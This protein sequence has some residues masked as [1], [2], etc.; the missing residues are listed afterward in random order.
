ML[1]VIGLFAAASLAFWSGRKESQLFSDPHFIRRNAG[2]DSLFAREKPVQEE[3]PHLFEGVRVV[4]NADSLEVRYPALGN[5]PENPV[6]NELVRA[7]AVQTASLGGNRLSLQV[8]GIAYPD[9]PVKTNFDYAVEME[10]AWFSSGLKPIP[11]KEVTKIVA[12]GWMRRLQFRGAFPEVKFLFKCDHPEEI[13]FMEQSVFNS[14]THQ[15]LTTGSSSW[16]SREQ[17]S[18]E[19]SIGLWYSAPVEVVLTV[20]Q[21]PVQTNKL[22]LREGAELSLPAGRLRLAAVIEHNAASWSS[23]SGGPTNTVR[24]SFDGREKE[25]QT[26][27]VFLAWPTGGAVPIDIE[28]IG[29]DGGTLPGGNGG[30]GSGNAVITS[31]RAARGGIREIRVKYYPNIKRVFFHLPEI[32]G[33]PERNRHVASLFDVRI[34]YLR[35]RYEHEYASVLGQLLGMDVKAF[36]YSIPPGTMPVT[37]TNATPRDILKDFERFLPP[38]RKLYVNSTSQSIEVRDPPLIELWKKIK[39]MFRW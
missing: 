23:S 33:L 6:A 11:S 32:P 15:Q 28:F 5:G 4:T 2:Y 38:N 24:L 31:T 39:K 27:C 21:G 19:S 3:P 18:F 36:G 7:N 30:G 25:P 34:P 10:G 29:Q 16:R 12:D 37:Y 9:Q 13:K 14:E 1:A 35:L 8:L 20:A 17:F 26:T 22:E